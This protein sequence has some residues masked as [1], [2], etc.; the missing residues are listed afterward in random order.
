MIWKYMHRHALLQAVEDKGS[1]LPNC[2]AFIDRTAR[3][4]CRPK[5]NQK[6]CFSGHK[7]MHMVKYQSLM[8]PNGIV[9][10]LDGHYP[11]SWHDASE[12][13]H[14][15]TTN[16]SLPKQPWLYNKRKHRRIQ[17]SLSLS[18]SQ[19]VTMA[20]LLFVKRN[21]HVCA[22]WYGMHC[23][24]AIAVTHEQ[25]LQSYMWLHSS[26]VTCHSYTVH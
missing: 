4:I 22:W 6:L 21:S 2:W 18:W 17:Q 7:R 8:C 14:S 12:F 11:G 19:P 10:Q 25:W 5:R 9:C 26:L 23:H 20:G 15:P 24:R 3:P 13:C 1:P 16:T